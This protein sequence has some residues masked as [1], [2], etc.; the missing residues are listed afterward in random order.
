MTESELVTK[1]EGFKYELL[2]TKTFMPATEAKMFESHM[3]ELDKEIMRLEEGS[4][5]DSIRGGL[6]QCLQLTQDDV[7]NL[8]PRMRSPYKD[9]MRSLVTA[10]G[11][12]RTNLALHLRGVTR[13][14]VYRVTVSYKPEDGSESDSEATKSV[15]VED[16]DIEATDADNAS[17]KATERVFREHRFGGPELKSIVSVHQVDDDIK[18]F[19]EADSPKLGI[20]KYEFRGE[21]QHTEVSSS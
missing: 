21:K 11:D 7:H 19:S 17:E 12:T 15:R 20:F 1:L 13:M 10:I 16:V 2:R 3:H 5:S 9:A 18:M 14:C 4:V 6:S 8:V